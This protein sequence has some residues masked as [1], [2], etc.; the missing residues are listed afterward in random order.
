MGFWV[1]VG[2]LMEYSHSQSSFI[3]TDVWDMSVIIIQSTLPT[4]FL[5]VVA[6]KC[7]NMY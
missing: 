3:S 4:S 2:F 1:E 6:E 5:S 7:I